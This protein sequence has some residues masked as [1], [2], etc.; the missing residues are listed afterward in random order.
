MKETTKVA[1]FFDTT[2]FALGAILLFLNA[3]SP[4]HHLLTFG[5]IFAGCG[6]AANLFF[7]IRDRNQSKSS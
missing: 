5:L 2:V 1:L 3:L 6:L 7:F 4:S